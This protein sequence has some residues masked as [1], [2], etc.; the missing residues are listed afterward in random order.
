[1]EKIFT[2]LLFFAAISSVAL[3]DTVILPASKD[4]TIYEDTLG[5]YSNGQGIYLYTGRTGTDLLRRA[6]IAFNLSSIPANA[7]VTSATL[8][9]NLNRRGPEIPGDI[10]LRKVLRDW[11]EGASDAGF[12]GGNGATAEPGDATWIHNFFDDSF[13]TNAGGD[14]S[15]T[16]S[17]STSVD[18]PGDYT[19]SGSGLIA[20]VQA[21]VSNPATNFG[22]GIIG[23]EVTA[24]SAAR[25]G[26]RENMNTPPQTPRLSVTYQVTGPTPTPTATP[27]PGPSATATPTATAT[28]TPNPTSTPAPTSTPTPTP[29]S[30]QA[31]NIAT[32]MRVETGSNVL[33]GGFI[34]NGNAT[35]NVAI[36]G[37][38]PS[39]A[40][41]GIADALADPTLEL[42]ASNGSV[43]FANDDWQENPQQAAELA[44]LALAPGNPK[45][46][47]IAITLQPGAYTAVLAGKNEGTGVGLVEVYDTNSAA[48]S[49][50]ANI[51]TRGFVRTAENVMIGGFILGGGSVNSRV[52]L[53]GIGPSLA[54][55]GLNPV[56]ADPTLELH[57]SNG[58]TLIANDDW[59]SDAASAAALTAAGFA[60]SDPKESGIFTSLPAGQFTAVLAG[61]NGGIGIGLVELYNL[62]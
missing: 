59:Q 8:T 57:D 7:T 53:R 44:N 30:P 12:P 56:L 4:N 51:S 42:R 61:K 28:A 19:W 39:L 24:G 5:Q 26:S 33:I 29:A 2:S 20:D 16:V 10:S 40:A 38:G 50:L 54:Q 46:S 9:L 27:T 15:S 32:R 43:I 37:I 14:F 41:F 34:I 52:A 6:L 22:W 31:L 62:H 47:G 18:I 1:M 17:A 23:N 48:N 13:W 3:A 35:K 55:F 11:G 36:R 60:L 58:T 45:E 21:W 49:Q 25:F